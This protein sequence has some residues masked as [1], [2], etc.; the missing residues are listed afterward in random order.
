[1]LKEKREVEGNKETGKPNKSLFLAQRQ[2]VF[3]FYTVL[4]L[5][6]WNSIKKYTYSTYSFAVGL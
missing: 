4:S 6:S 1:M 2:K 5:F 3:F